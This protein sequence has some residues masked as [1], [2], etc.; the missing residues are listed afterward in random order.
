MNLTLQRASG[1][2]D[3]IEA[4]CVA[5]HLHRLGH[6]IRF[7][8]SRL[9][10][11]ILEGHPDIAEVALT[12]T[13]TPD[14]D[15]GETEA[16]QKVTHLQQCFYDV[17]LREPVIKKLGIT[18]ADFPMIQPRLMVNSEASAYALRFMSLFPRPW[19]VLAHMSWQA[20]NRTVP[21]DIWHR[22]RDRSPSAT[23]FNPTSHPLRAPFLSSGNGLFSGVIASIAHADL[24]VTVDSG[25][26]HVAAAL[27]KPMVAIQQGWNVSLRIPPGCEYR[28]VRAPVD[29]SPCN[30]HSCPIPGA[31]LA[32]PCCQEFDAREIAEAVE[33]MLPA[34]ILNK[35]CVSTET[36]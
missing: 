9:C 3:V 30:M 17:A 7:Q 28:V 1:F 6:T 16:A 24:V 31:V 36:A 18:E 15:L 29:C 2:G 10:A 12:G 4:T 11:P 20:P 23:W 34:S 35:T 27:G 13:G 22:V 32:K 33:E 19:I 5:T 8:T 21:E 14:I 25:P 26:L